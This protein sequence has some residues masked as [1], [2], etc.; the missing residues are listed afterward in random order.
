MIIFEYNE[1]GGFVTMAQ[2]LMTVESIMEFYEKVERE[3]INGW[4]K[5]E[6]GELYTTDKYCDE[7]FR[8]EKVDEEY[9]NYN[10]RYVILEGNTYLVKSMER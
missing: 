8:L 10:D 5:I 7:I 1:N 3:L 4:I 6:K 9:I 2:S